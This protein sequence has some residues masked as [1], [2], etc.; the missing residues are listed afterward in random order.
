MF[1]PLHKETRVHP[2]LTAA[3]NASRY[4]EMRADAE[5]RRSQPR[6]PRARRL[7][8]GRRAAPHQMRARAA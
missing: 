8:R 2:H 3:V 5:R 6:T 4:D 7:S 1:D